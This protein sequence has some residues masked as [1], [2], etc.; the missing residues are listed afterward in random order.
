MGLPGLPPDFGLCLCGMLVEHPC[1]LLAV[2][3]VFCLGSCL[4]PVEYERISVMLAYLYFREHLEGN[5]TKGG[6]LQLCFPCQD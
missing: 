4:Y 6:G 1:L 3:A 5:E 2:W